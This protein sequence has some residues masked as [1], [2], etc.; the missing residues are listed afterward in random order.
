MSDWDEFHG[1]FVAYGAT[2]WRRVCPICGRY[3]TADKS[4]QINWLTESP[5]DEPNATCSAH[6]RVKMPFE[7]WT[8]DLEAA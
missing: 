8:G 4:I 5:A 7:C 2:V 6:G 3:V 1:P